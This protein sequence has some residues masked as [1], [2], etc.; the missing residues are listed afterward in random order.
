MKSHLIPLFI[1]LTILFAAC[2]PAAPVQEVR[3]TGTPA[4]VPFS[5]DLGPGGGTPKTDAPPPEVVW[6]PDPET[7][8]GSGTFCCGFTTPTVPLNYIPDF[9]IW[10]DGRYV[11]VVYNSDNSRQ[12]LQG[13][14]TEDQ[15]TAL[16]QKAVDAGFFG[17]E[18]RYAND[19]VADLAE[20]CITITLESATKKV[21][22]YA[23]G[24]PEAFHTLYD[25][26]ASGNGIKGTDFVPTR[27]YLTAFDLGALAR[28][29]SQDDIA[30]PADQL[31]SLSTAIDKGVWAEGDALLLAWQAVNQNPWEGLVYEGE[32]FFGIGLQIPGLSMNPPPATQ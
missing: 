31:F 21:C 19:L 13:Q 20:K 25:N 5:D 29:I 28:P 32:N 22:E 10:G 12:V 15:L 17:W 16:L 2:Q 6:N 23:K 18:D 24:A 11:W 26:F 30:W 4:R 14:L 7:L 27:G 8:I 3:A 1:G 9:Q